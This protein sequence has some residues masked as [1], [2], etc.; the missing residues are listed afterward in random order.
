MDQQRP[1]RRLKETYVEEAIQSSAC[2]KYYQYGPFTIQNP[3]PTE[4]DDVLR[5]NDSKTEGYIYLPTERWIMVGSIDG[6][7]LR[8]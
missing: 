3:E 6:E 1:W 5:L 2:E 7:W 4:Y 8:C